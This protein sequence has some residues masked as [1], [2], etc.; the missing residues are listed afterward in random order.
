VRHP[1]A[2]LSHLLDV[3][4]PG[5]DERH[6]LAGLHHMGAGIP[7]DRTRS[8]DGYLPVHAVL[9]ASLGAEGSVPARPITTVEPRAP[10][11]H[12]TGKTAGRGPAF[13]GP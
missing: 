5:I 13:R 4:G 3:L 2:V 7:A 6:V 12:I 8:D 11:R 1:Q 9:P 10:P